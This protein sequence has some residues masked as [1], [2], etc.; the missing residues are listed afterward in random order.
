MT[1]LARLMRWLMLCTIA[2]CVAVAVGG[3][4]AITSARPSS[5]SGT[6]TIGI[7]TFRYD[8]PK[9]ARVQDPVTI[10]GQTVVVRG[11]VVDGVVRL[12]TA[13]TP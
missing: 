5:S 1:W 8:V 7:A 13:F 6:T 10:G 12:G 2:A 11:A 9:V 4:A 3:P